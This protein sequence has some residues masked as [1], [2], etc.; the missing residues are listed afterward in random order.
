MERFEEFLTARK[1]LK[2]VSDKTPVYYKVRFQVMGDAVARRR[3][4]HAGISGTGMSPLIANASQVK[5][6]PWKYWTFRCLTLKI[7]RVGHWVEDFCTVRAVSAIR[8]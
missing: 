3:R 2:N 6:R 5:A 7:V 1:Y 4:I 8:L